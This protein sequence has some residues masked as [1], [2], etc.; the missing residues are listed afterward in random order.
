MA[1]QPNFSSYFQP[2]NTKPQNATIAKDQYKF[3]FTANEAASQGVTE[4]KRLPV[5][6]KKAMSLARAPISTYKVG[7]VGRASSG[8]V[9]LGVNVDFPGLPLHHSIHAE[10]FLVANLALNSEEG[11]RHLAVAVS[12][13]GI[14]F[15]TPCGHCCQFLLEI[16]NAPDIK[17]LS[18]SKHVEV[19]FASLR[20]LLTDRFTPN[21]ILPNGTPLLLEKRDNC[22]SLSSSA[23][24]EICSESYSY[25]LKWTA[26]EAANNSFSPYT[27]SP[28][29]VALLDD[30]WNVYRGWYIESVASNPSLGPVQAALVDFVARGRGKGF[31]KIVGAVLVEKN[32]ARVSQEGTAKMLLETIAYPN[33][34]FKVLH[35]YVD[36]LKNVKNVGL[37]Y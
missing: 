22:L 25:R 2:P 1:E 37:R 32:G 16:S 14:E 4:P 8:R 27:D 35:C 11:L 9:Y 34:G 30:E 12:T 6:I 10:Q 23:S 15:G 3:V 31:D 17:I 20:C 19:S 28:S 29:G 26:L 21:R 24:G 18:R 33:C 13:D 36:A 7:A 5:L